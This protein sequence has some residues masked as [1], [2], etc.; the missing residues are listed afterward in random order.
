MVGAIVGSTKREPLVVGKPSD[1]MLDNIANTFKL[2]RDQI[3]MVGDRLDTDILFGAQAGLGATLLVYTGV[4]QRGEVAAL[5]A[6][7]ARTPSHELDSLGDL[8]QLLEQWGVLAADGGGA[9]GARR[10]GIRGGPGRRHP[11]ALLRARQ[12]ARPA[13]R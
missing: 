11:V 8:A 6:G 1:F 4:T 7:D 12:R 3:C 10:A 9:A 5:P 13:L 2:Q